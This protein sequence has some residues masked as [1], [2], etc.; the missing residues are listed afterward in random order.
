MEQERQQELKGLFHMLD[1]TAKIAE[2][3]IVNRHL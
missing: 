3:A 2:D 1:H